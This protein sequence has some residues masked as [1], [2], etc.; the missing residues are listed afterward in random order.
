[1]ADTLGRWLRER[2][3]D[4]E[5]QDC[6][7]A[8]PLPPEV[9]VEVTTDTA[10]SRYVPSDPG[11]PDEQSGKGQILISFG[12]LF[13]KGLSLGTGYATSALTRSRKT[14]ADLHTHCS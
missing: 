6:K 2:P 1:M 8:D 10:S 5:S 7:A 4:S 13:E 3:A 9:V 11:A 14:L 12:K